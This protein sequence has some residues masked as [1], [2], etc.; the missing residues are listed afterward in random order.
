MHGQRAREAGGGRLARPAKDDTGGQADMRA[1]GIRPAW[2][3]YCQPI[4]W[5][6]RLLTAGALITDAVVHLQDAYYYDPNTGSLLS[7]GELFRVQ[8][9][10]AIAV[11]I[12]VLA[13]P[14]WPSWVLALLVTASAVGAVVTY[15]YVDLGP[16]AGLPSMYEPTWGPPGKL[17]SACAEGAGVVLSLAGLGWALARRRWLR[18]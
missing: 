10:V 8:S 3:R 9:G 14:R 12:L 1:A 2:L 13:W 11:A 18:A 17:L 6:L 15:T 4:G 16:V 7:E 5:I